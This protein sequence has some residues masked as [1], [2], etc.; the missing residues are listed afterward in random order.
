[1]SIVERSFSGGHDGKG[2]SPW[3]TKPWPVF[4]ST[5]TYQGR[6]GQILNVMADCLQISFDGKVENC[7]YDEVEIHAPEGIGRFDPA[8][9]AIN[10]P[11]H[12]IEAS[13]AAAK[14]L[15]QRDWSSW[16]EQHQSSGWGA[17]GSSNHLNQS[18]LGKSTGGLHSV[19]GGLHAA[20][21]HFHNTAAQM[22]AHEGSMT[23]KAD[24]FQLAQAHHMAAARILAFSHSLNDAKRTDEAERARLAANHH[25]DAADS[26]RRGDRHSALA[27][28]Y[29]AN[30]HLQALGHAEN[31]RDDNWN[32][33]GHPFH[34]NQHT[35]GLPGFGGPGSAGGHTPGEIA[36]G[37]AWGH[38]Y[39]EAGAAAEKGKH[40]AKGGGAIDKATGKLKKAVALPGLLSK[41]QKK[42]MNKGQGQFSGTSGG[43]GGGKKYTAEETAAY[44]AKKEAEAAAKGAAQKKKNDEYAAS[45]SQ[46]AGGYDKRDLHA[47]G[48]WGPKGH[49]SRYGTVMFDG[50]GHVLI[51]EPSGHFDGIAA[52]FSK[53]GPDPG[54]HPAMTAI[55]ESEEETGITPRII[56]HIKGG[57]T[58]TS[59]MNHYYIA[60]PSEKPFDAK[61]MNGETSKLMWA[62]P[63]QADHL[64]QGGTNAAGI[65]RD[66]RTLRAAVSTY[67]EMHPDH[68]KSEPLDPVPP[69]QPKSASVA[70][71]QKS[72]IG[73]PVLLPHTSEAPTEEHH[74]DAMSKV[75]GPKGSTPSQW[76]QDH[77]GQRYLLKQSK[78]SDHAENEVAVGA[79]YHAAGI[80]TPRTNLITM[81]DGTKHVVSKAVGG[82]QK[83]RTNEKNQAEARKGAGIDALVSNWD[84]L[85]LVN[86]N[87]FTTSKGNVVRLDHGG[88]GFYR[89]Q[90]KP[91]DEGFEAGKPWVDPVT[92]RTSKQGKE[93][94]GAPPGT[95]DEEMRA[96]LVAAKNLDLNKVDA[97]MASRGVSKEFRQD[98]LAVPEGPSGQDL[99]RRPRRSGS[100]GG[101]Q[102]KCCAAEA[103]RRC[104]LGCG[105]RQGLREQ[106]R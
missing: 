106:G 46:Y 85:G 28:T 25:I 44:N 10:E 6:T 80:P 62:T 36:A 89:A 23:S 2:G 26:A 7:P 53:G 72:K 91:K 67:E 57:F 55:R 34:G 59:S 33:E 49:N 63:K 48:A 41:S 30:H 92:Q 3:P 56:G 8:S 9:V 58:G 102:G 60:V 82:L 4:G 68:P 32:G 40:A 31:F 14:P 99:A 13:T 105:G 94:Y 27:N 97:E 12:G 84:T 70:Q 69:L 83:W 90:G 38:A 81:E 104:G 29:Y 24:R 51:R 78:S 98:Y 95:H 101:G 20:S 16:D 74:L 5:G 65:N 35:G 103:R 88:G 19:L 21:L 52:A 79:T 76:Y 15:A 42:A 96:S 39:G 64:M 75:Q 47:E 37:K 93:L 66:R 73:P 11:V 1:M 43:K 22:Q 100:G 45:R 54:E 87:A 50:K 61:M 18:G 71:V 17:F 86:D 77:L